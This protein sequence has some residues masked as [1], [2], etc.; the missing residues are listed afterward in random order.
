MQLDRLHI[1]K[2]LPHHSANKKFWW[3]LTFNI[4]KDPFKMTFKRV[5]SRYKE[6][7]KVK[8]K[9]ICLKNQLILEY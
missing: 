4:P 1:Y 9:Q 7:H 5:K 8:F 2:E 6:P 3:P